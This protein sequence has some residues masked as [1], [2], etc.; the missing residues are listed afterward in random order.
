MKQTISQTLR[1]LGITANYRGYRQLCVAVKLV[2]LDEDATISVKKNVYIPTAEI[3]HCNHQTIERNIRT[4]IDRVWRMNR[5]YL[6]EMAGYPLDDPPTATEFI[7]MIANHV[8]CTCG[9]N[10]T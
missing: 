1:A 9:I 6:S 10:V 7:D 3:L 5:P 4:V 2:V 8:R